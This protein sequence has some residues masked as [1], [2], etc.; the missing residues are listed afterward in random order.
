MKQGD[1]VRYLPDGDT[2]T[3]EH[4]D[5]LGYTDRGTEVVFV[6]IVNDDGLRYTALPEDLEEL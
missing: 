4:V 2:G 3:V 5:H 6:D 1:R